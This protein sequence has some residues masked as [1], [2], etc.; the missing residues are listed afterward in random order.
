MQ[1]NIDQPC[2]KRNNGLAD[3]ASNQ[4]LKCKYLSFQI[5]LLH[6]L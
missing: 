4:R 1:V 3:Y 2:R 5:I 6:H